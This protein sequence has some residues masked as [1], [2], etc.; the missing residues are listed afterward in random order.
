MSFYK[1]EVVRG[2]RV[3]KKNIRRKVRKGKKHKLTG[4]VK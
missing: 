1:E 4:E 3:K 2:R